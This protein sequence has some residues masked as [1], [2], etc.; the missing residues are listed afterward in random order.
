MQSRRLTSLVAIIATSAMFMT[1]CSKS[2]TPTETYGNS[3]ISLFGTDGIMDSSFGQ[4]V[5][6][7][8]ALNG[9]SG[10]A[11]LN[12][13]TPAFASRLRKIDSSLGSLNYAGQAYD[14]VVITALATQLADSTNGARIASYIDGVTTLQKG[15]QECTD[16]AGCLALIKAGTDI[17]YRGI[18]VT[19]GFT[20]VGEPSTAS[21]GTLHFD[22]SNQID[23]QKTEY[24][25]AGN[26]GT[27]STETPPA[28]VD[29]SHYHGP[30]LDF[31]L[32]LPKTGGLAGPGKPIIAATK[33]AL[34]DINAAGG[35]LG[36]PVSSDFADD[37]TLTATAVS[38]A[39]RLIHDGVSVI[40]GPS[41]SAAAA[42][43]VPL[44]V[45]AHVVVFTPSAT[46]ADLTTIDDHGLF[47]RTAP[48][49]DLQAAALADIIMRSGVQ[50]VFIVSRGDSYG[51]G[52]E[53]SVTAALASDGMAS[54]DMTTAEYSVDP[55][56]NNSTTT[57]PQIAK[58]IAAFHANAVLLI[59]YNE[60]AGMID[61]MVA[62]HMTFNQT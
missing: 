53:H 39:K 49:D 50:K 9:M 58:S 4:A 29:S 5:K 20:K 12:P 60:I 38:G 47:F 42:A 61:A 46:S 62:A 13:V 56:V 18:T 1:A 11:A 48:S 59:G 32:L 2:T 54:S 26:A 15:G 41:F 51:T 57:Y 7:A 28:P 22:S 52:L 44:A 31:G 34:N 24:V 19:D 14:A 55:G 17:A 25:N 16:F 27:T 6:S 40:I 8:G 23:D 43:V 10:T 21:Y 33:L 30:A 37:G 45:A 35:V 36:K 3:G